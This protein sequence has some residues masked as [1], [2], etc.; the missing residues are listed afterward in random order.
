MSKS[1]LC[2]AVSE[3]RLKK[4]AL[5]FVGRSI[6]FLVLAGRHSL[7]A[8]CQLVVSDVLDSLVD[9]L[10]IQAAAHPRYRYFITS[11]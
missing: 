3:H 9:A 1:V 10:V 6:I 5:S 7:V 4:H 8:T 11:P 2:S